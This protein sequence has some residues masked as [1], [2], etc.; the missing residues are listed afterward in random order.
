[1]CQWQIFLTLFCFLLIKSGVIAADNSV[2]V[3][4]ILLNLGLPL[5]GLTIALS[6]TA[7]ELKVNR[8]KNLNIDRSMSQELVHPGL[9][10][11]DTNSSTAAGVQREMSVVQEE[12]GQHSLSR[13]SSY[14]ELE[15]EEKYDSRRDLLEEEKFDS[16]RDLVEQEEAFDTKDTVHELHDTEG[17]EDLA[18]SVR[19]TPAK[20]ISNKVVPM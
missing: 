10:Q 5:V 1:M 3:V 6:D 13:R 17:S 20:K 7:Y 4:L 12:Q 14:R 19:T 9:P 8:T 15:T 2:G 11:G 18:S 16:R